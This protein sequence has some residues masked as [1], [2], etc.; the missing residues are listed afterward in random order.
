[1]DRPCS[2]RVNGGPCGAA[3]GQIEVTVA[4]ERADSE[5]LAEAAA[6]G[7]LPLEPATTS[8]PVLNPGRGESIVSAA[9]H[10]QRSGAFVPVDG[11]V[12]SA[13]RQLITMVAVEVAGNQGA[14]E[15]GVGSQPTLQAGTLPT[16]GLRA[17]GREAVG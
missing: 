6:L 16:P 9:Q 17:S 15:V 1:M 3:H 12:G 11:V 8:R 13:D 5:D 14:A 7:R 10:I 4:G 2:A